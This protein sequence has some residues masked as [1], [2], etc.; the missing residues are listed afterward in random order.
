MTEI[1]TDTVT[2]ATA[3]KLEGAGLWRRASARWR[4]VMQG[5]R[6]SDKQ[7]E[8]VRQRRL[9]C[10]SMVPGHR[11][12]PIVT[13]ISEVSRAAAATQKRMGLSRTSRQ[14]FTVSFGTRSGKEE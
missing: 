4:T 1:P 13:G 7:R 5:G 3:E 6:L 8:W 10:Q 9:Y 11:P 14:A 12:E 2:D